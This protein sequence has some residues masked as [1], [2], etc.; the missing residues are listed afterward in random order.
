MTQTIINLGT[1]GAVL[2][3][4]SGSTGSADSNDPKFLNWDGVNHVYLPGVAGNYLSVPDE[5][6]LDIT[7]DIDIRVQVAMDDWTPSAAHTLLSKRESSGDQ[8]SFTLSVRT[9]GVLRL[10]W[11]VSGTAASQV[12]KD[13]TIATGIADNSVKWIR[14]TLDVDNGSSGNDVIFSLSDDGIA[15]TQLGSTVTTAGVTSI[16][17]GTAPVTVGSVQTSVDMLAAKIYRAQILNGIDGTK[18]LD[19]DTSVITSGAATSFTALT[20]QTVTINRSTSGRKAVAVVSPCWLFGTDDY[21]E[22]ADNDLLDFGA[23]DSFTVLAVVRQWVTAVG[24]GIYV[25]KQ[26]GTGAANVGYM[27][28]RTSAQNPQ[29]I[30][31]DGSIIDSVA[32]VLS[33]TGALETIAGIRD[34]SAVTIGINVNGTQNSNS[35]GVTGSLSN[36]LPLRIGRRSGASTAYQDF[37]LLAVAVF[38]RALTST[39]ITALTT[40]FQGRVN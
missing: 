22:V 5:A 29:F 13:S 6:A 10:E 7:G 1:G 3:A 24:N 27:L 35:D 17:S 39:E 23:S 8:R 9:N 26:D 15:W 30:F 16:Y 21:M 38:R 2:N 11:F 25:A 19:V 14:A 18:V 34:R 37:E 31:A 32:V 12:I 4:Q 20:G 28:Y 36:A 40:Y 33:P